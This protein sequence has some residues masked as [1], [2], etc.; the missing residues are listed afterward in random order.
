MAETTEQIIREDP[1]IE[2]F[3]I[4]LLESGKG[5]AEVPI[6]LPT[7][8]VADFSGLQQAAIQQQQAGIGGG[9][10]PNT[11]TQLDSDSK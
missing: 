9:K 10:A 5:L 2:A 6:T 3:K 4:G 8:K 11:L 1:A 7:Q